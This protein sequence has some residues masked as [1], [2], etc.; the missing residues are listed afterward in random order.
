MVV[1]TTLIK[2]M[3]AVVVVFTFSISAQAQ[4]LKI[5]YVN[6]PKLIDKAPQ[7]AAALKKLEAEFGPRDKELRAMR[8]DIKRLETDLGKNSLI[9]GDS[10]RLQKENKI[11]ALQ[12]K[13]RRM[14]QEF[15]DDFNLRKNEELAKLQKTITAAIVK[16]SI[17]EK[18]DLVLQNVVYVNPSLDITQKVLDKL[19]N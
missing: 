13:L 15:K 12:R 2:V 9:L 18:Y 6:A 1:R 3:I 16:I 10:Q 7:K 8:D 19:G 14:N 11:R 5:G 17:E 4:A